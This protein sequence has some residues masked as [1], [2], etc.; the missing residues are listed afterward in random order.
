M[1]AERKKSPGG[2]KPGLSF[3][4]FFFS[5]YLV[6]TQARLAFDHSYW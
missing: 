4:S 5:F 3:T 2:Y 6:L 1:P